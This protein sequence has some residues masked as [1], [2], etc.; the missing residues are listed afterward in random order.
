MLMRMPCPDGL[1]QRQTV[2]LFSASSPLKVPVKQCPPLAGPRMKL[3]HQSFLT[4]APTLSIDRDELR[5]QQSVHE[6]LSKVMAWLERSNNRPPLGPLKHS[7]P[8][9]RKLWHE[10][11]KLTRQN[12]ILCRKVKPGPQTSPSFQVVLPEVLIPTA[13]KGHAWKPVQWTF[14]CRAHF[15]KSQTHLLLAIHVS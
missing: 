2:K 6:Y 12:G 14:K 5:Q 8:T 10:C 11:P 7:S 3:P 9:L 1:P 4:S 15:T 13:F